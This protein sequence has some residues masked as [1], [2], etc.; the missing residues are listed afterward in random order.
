[1]IIYHFRPY[2]MAYDYSVEVPDG[3]SIPP[4]F[5]FEKPPE[6]NGYHAVMK[7]GWVLVEGPLPPLPPPDPNEARRTMVAT[8]LQAKVALYNAGLLDEVENYIS[9]ETTNVVVKLAWN[10]AIQYERLSPMIE[11]IGANLGLTP[12]QIDNLFIEAAQISV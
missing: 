2:D 10:N 6:K 5:A 11:N 8:P 9:S 4:F 3:P 12:E 1:M 7:E